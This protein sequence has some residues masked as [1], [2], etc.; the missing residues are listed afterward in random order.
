MA[1]DIYIYIR[2]YIYVCMYVC[3]YVGRNEKSER[4]NNLNSL[5]RSRISGKKQ[6]SSFARDEKN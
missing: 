2:I 5:K 4:E 6:S 1:R 3:T